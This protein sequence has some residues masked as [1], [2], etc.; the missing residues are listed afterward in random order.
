MQNQKSE[1]GKFGEDFSV[2]YL[3]NHN[4]K[5]LDRNYRLKFGE[6]DIVAQKGKTVVFCEVKTRIKNDFASP[7]DNV[8]FKKQKKLI[9]LA[10]LY[11]IKNKYPQNQEWQIDIIS[12][13]V[14]RQSKKSEIR[15]LEQAIFY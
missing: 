12:I 7:E 3:E 14:D 1:L 2:Q 8:N 15:H 6:L 9:R 11:L 4:Y 13:D 5:I 10:E